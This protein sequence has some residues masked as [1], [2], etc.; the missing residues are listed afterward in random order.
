MSNPTA[1]IFLAVVFLSIPIIAILNS[2]HE[3]F[4]F[5]ENFPLYHKLTLHRIMHLLEK[6]NIP[7][8]HKELHTNL[9]EI[10]E[11]K[12]PESIITNGTFKLFYNFEKKAAKKMKKLWK[13]NKEFKEDDLIDLIKTKR[14]YN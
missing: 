5:L 3:N 8:L 2:W 10:A 7:I 4:D 6:A 14:N 12:P 13:T 9:I 1:M 11:R